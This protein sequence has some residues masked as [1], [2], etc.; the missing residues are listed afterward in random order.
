MKSLVLITSNFPFGNSESFIAQELRLISNAYEKVIII[1]QN[2]TGKEARST[3]ENVKIYRYNS[4]TS[5]KG[6]LYLPLLFFI[7]SPAISEI[8]KGEIEFRLGISDIFTARKFFYLFKKVIKAVQLKEYIIQK[9]KQEGIENS[10]VFYS[11]WLKTGAHAAAMLNYSNSIKVARGHGSDIYEENTVKR[12]LPL[13]K[14]SALNLDAIFFV[15]NQGKYYFEKKVRIHSPRFTVSYLGV[16]K[17]DTTSKEPVKSDNYVIVSCSNMISLKR[18]DLIIDSL[19]MVTSHRKIQWIHFGDGILKNELETYA[20]KRLGPL[21]NISYRFMGHYPNN[22]LLK[23]Y[24]EHHV[25]LFLNTSSTEGVPVSIME[26]QSFSIPVIATDAGGVK[27]LVREGTGTILPVDFKPYDLAKLIDHYSCL[28][29][30]EENKIRINSYLNWKS[31]FRASTNYEDFIMQLNSIFDSS[32][33]KQ[34]QQ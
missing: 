14:F 11:Y 26:A 23:Y 25:D 16:E 10:I 33:K 6:F 29:E 2:V 28:S 8:L 21:K 34:Q 24:S 13:L 5:V 15:S 17:P 32:I 18:I 20:E 1:A 12:Y 3:P 22:E 30:E 4:S 9:L 27:E 7:N 31:N 19:E